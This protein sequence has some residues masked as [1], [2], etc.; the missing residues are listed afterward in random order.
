MNERDFCQFTLAIRFVSFLRQAY[1][2]E[3]LK[4]FEHTQL[5]PFC[6]I[7]FYCMGWVSGFC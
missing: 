1:C 2:G 7:L 6:S 3:F 5:S 4:D